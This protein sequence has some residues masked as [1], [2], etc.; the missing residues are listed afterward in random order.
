MPQPG[1]IFAASSG[2]ESPHD[3]RRSSSSGE[4]RARITET[5]GAVGF[6]DAGIVS[7]DATFSSTE[8]LKVGV[9][10]GARYYTGFGPLR[11]D[12]AFPLEPG[13][14]DADFAFYIGI[15]QAF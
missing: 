11:F 13:P 12:L 4:V 5:I 2:C 15:G 6:V 1:A 14:D 7:A 8:D 10:V 9:G 3:R